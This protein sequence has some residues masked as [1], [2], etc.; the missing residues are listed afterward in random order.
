VLA[1]G[2]GRARAAAAGRDLVAIAS[3]TGTSGDPQHYGAQVHRLAAAGIVVEPDN[4]SAAALAA[5]VIVAA[6]SAGGRRT[7]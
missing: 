2:L 1:E 7:G 3:V 6:A 4:R 5:A